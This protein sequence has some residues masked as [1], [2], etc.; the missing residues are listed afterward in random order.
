[1]KIVV[2]GGTGLL[3][4]AICRAAVQKGLQVHAVSRHGKTKGLEDAWAN[5]VSW[6]SIDVQNDTKAL[7]PL[8]KDSSCLVNTIGILMENNYKKILKKP[9][10][11]GIRAL[12]NF[13]SFLPS[14][15]NNNPLKNEKTTKSPA[16]KGSLF[17]AINE[18]LAVKLGALASQNNV[19]TYCYISTH[20]YFPGIDPEYVN[21]KR[22]AE[23][24]IQS[25]P[26]LRSIF[27][28]PSFMYDRHAR[29]ISEP[30]SLLFK[31]TSGLKDAV[32]GPKAGVDN[33]LVAPPLP[34]ASVG[35]AIVEAICDP[36][37]HGV[38]SV[39][40]ILRLAE[41]AT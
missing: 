39:N 40:D 19:P 37:V 7:T 16:Q 13:P 15:D 12:K 27:L 31:M 36:S 1:M 26:N 22:R 35:A 41:K 18:N 33:A 5:H 10:S 32:F 29:P 11:A 28:R 14:K 25:I 24:R 21:S 3:G 23:Q 34:T 8:L 20:G 17:K 9:F 30:I 6:H 4:Q 2:A 38:V